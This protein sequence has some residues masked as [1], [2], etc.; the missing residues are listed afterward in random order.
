MRIRAKDLQPALVFEETTQ[1]G[2]PAGKPTGD[3]SIWTERMLTTLSNGVQGGKWYS[4]GDKALSVKALSAAFMRVKANGGAPGMDG[5]MDGRSSAS[6]RSR[7][8][9]YVA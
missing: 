8:R 3:P 9:I 5:W 7:K 6:R 4:L 2:D 1:A